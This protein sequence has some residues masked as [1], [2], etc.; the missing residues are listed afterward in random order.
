[1]IEFEINFDV[2][3][4]QGDGSDNHVIDDFLDLV[5][6]LRAFHFTADFFLGTDVRRQLRLWRAPQL[7]HARLQTRIRRVRSG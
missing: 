4:I 3:R 1:M 6:V 2:A 5:A 7:R